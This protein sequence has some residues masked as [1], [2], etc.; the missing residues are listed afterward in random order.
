VL[1]DEPAVRKAIASA[2]GKTRRNCWRLLGS[3]VAIA[4]VALAV[5]VAG[6]WLWQTIVPSSS[7]VGA[8]VIGETNLLLLL[9]TRFWQRAVAV[10]F[11]VQELT[12][13][14]EEDGRAVAVFASPSV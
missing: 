6:I 7:V 2:F 12:R 14:V 5:L 10:A 11:H 1:R 8:F 4:L 13:P 3:Y 9:A